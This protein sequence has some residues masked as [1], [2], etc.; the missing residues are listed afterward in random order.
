MLCMSSKNTTKIM[1]CNT[2]DSAMSALIRVI[3]DNFSFHL[4]PD[5]GGSVDSIQ[6]VNQRNRRL[7]SI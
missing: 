3:S 4:D 2:N 5:P 7:D 1:I 6:T